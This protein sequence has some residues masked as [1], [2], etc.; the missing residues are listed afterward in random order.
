MKKLNLFWIFIFAG[1]CFSCENDTE[2]SQEQEAQNLK[3]MFSE[4]ESLAY[5]ESCKDSSNWTFTSIG[6]KACGGPAGF[7]AYSLN[8]DTELFLEKINQHKR[9]QEEFNKKWGISSD[10]S[11]PPQPS[12]VECENG[13][14]VLKY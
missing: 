7:I 11:L 4:I 3:L 6:S 8:I 12:G 9:A 2:M 14:P 1:I 10:C 5:S 13:K